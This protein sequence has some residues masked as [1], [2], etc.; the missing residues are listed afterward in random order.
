MMR[1]SKILL[2]I[3][4]FALLFTSCTKG[5]YDVG[6]VHGVTAQGELLLPVATQ[7]F[8]VMDMM[9]RF[10]LTDQVNWTE[11]GNMSF[12]FSYENIA[13]I[14]GAELLKFKDLDFEGHYTFPNPYATTTPPYVDTVVSFEHQLIFESDEV[15]VLRAEMKSGRLDF[16]VESNIGAVQHVVIHSSDIK[17]AMGHDFELGLPVQD[18]AFG[19]NL[20]DLLFVTDEPNTL[21][22]GFELHIHVPGTTDPELYV[23]VKAT[24]VDLAFREMRGYVDAY[25]SRNRIDSV[26]TLFPDNLEGVLEVEGARI[27]VKE[28]NTFSLGAKLVVDTALLYNE[29]MPPVSLLEPLPLVVDMPPQLQLDEVFNQ[30]I[31]GTLNVAGGRAFSTSTFIVNPEGFSEL[32][33]V[34]D[35]C[36]IDTEVDVE[37]PF[38]FKVDDITYLDTA[39]MDL[40]NLEFPDLIEE[41]TLE[42]TFV[43]TLPLN[44]RASFYA[45]D[46]ENDRIT[47]TLLVNETVIQASQDGRPMTTNVALVVDESRIEKVLHSDRI[48]M[49]YLLDSGDKNVALNVNQR[50]D[51]YLKIK[52]KYNDTV[53]FNG[54]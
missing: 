14:S 13:V 7:S 51:L 6:N 36:R 21:N 18:N 8:T 43:S 41:L 49:A 17:D 39:N 33:T 48:I 34:V 23:D 20:D 53:E 35:T 11:E 26:F 54:N 22:I 45:Y 30:R 4:A 24:G 1:S 32:V 42:L 2:A 50:I 5:H 40:A 12:G 9:E 16:M 25:E 44:L 47:D 27:S 28:R 31:N 52:A 15:H 46:S 29:G 37:I 10:E 3:M 19:F 38:S